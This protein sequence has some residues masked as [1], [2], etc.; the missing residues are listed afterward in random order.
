MKNLRKYIR[1]I[2]LEAQFHQSYLDQ[3][4]HNRENTPYSPLGTSHREY[5]KEVNQA[6][7]NIDHPGHEDLPSDEEI[8]AKFDLRRDVKKFWNENADHEYWQDPNKVIA[9][10][11]LS[12]YADLA[13][14]DDEKFA[15]DLKGDIDLKIESFLKKYP[16][17]KIQKDEMSTYGYTSMNQFLDRDSDHHR[18]S[19]AVILNPRRVTF[20]SRADAYTESRGSAS[21]KDLKR[22]AGSGLPK[23]PSIGKYFQGKGVL[24]DEGDV[25]SRQSV[26]K[27]GIGELIIDNWSYDTLV[28]NTGYNKHLSV[29]RV[30]QIIKAAKKHGL[31]VI[32]GR[33]GEEL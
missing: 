21:E 22:H 12:Y 18:I 7:R 11:D 9:I 28:I 13:E 6:K 29:K 16:P 2:L 26:S 4:V 31:K 33:H 15:E 14:D 30:K 17:G 5:E 24:F 23:R 1:E 27:R 19:L 32:D 3:F 20:A 8:D 10:H 25:T